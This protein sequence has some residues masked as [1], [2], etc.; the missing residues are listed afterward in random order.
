MKQSYLTVMLS[1][2]K[3]GAISFGGGSA[4]IP[5]IEDEMSPLAYNDKIH[6]GYYLWCFNDHV[7]YC[8]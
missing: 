8:N 1:F 2:I 5:V 4:L 3:M 7:F 6:D